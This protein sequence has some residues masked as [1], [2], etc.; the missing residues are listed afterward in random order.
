MKIFNQ[1]VE[2][3]S[4]GKKE[5]IDVKN[6][7]LS[8]LGK[9]TLAALPET[10]PAEFSR[11][12]PKIERWKKEYDATGLGSASRAMRLMPVAISDKKT[13]KDYVA[14]VKDTDIFK[15]YQ[16]GVG[17]DVLGTVD[18]VWSANLR[19]SSTPNV[20]NHP[21]LKSRFMDDPKRTPDSSRGDLMLD[22]TRDKSLDTPAVKR[23]MAHYDQLHALLKK[24]DA[25]VRAL[26]NVFHGGFLGR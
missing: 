26:V 16:W 15:G 2:K 18:Q 23:E 25:G 17:T 3:Q 13:Q 4:F 6:D 10:G 5:F 24:Q 22:H 21:W 8:M 7:V 14:A 19:A 20:I 12:T 1:N 9:S 11:R